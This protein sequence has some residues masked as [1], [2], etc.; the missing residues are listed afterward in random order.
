M[1]NQQNYPT[2]LTQAKKHEYKYW[3]TKPVTSLENPSYISQNIEKN[4][5]NRKVYASNDEI[6][7]PDS[8]RWEKI[9]ISDK[10]MMDKI[11]EFLQKHY[12]IDDTGKFI[13]HYTT[14]FLQWAIGKDNICL[15]IISK[16]T[17]SVCGFVSASF[18]ILT[19]FEA[20]KKFAV[21][22]FLCAHPIYRSKNIAQILIDEIVRQ[23]V[24]TGVHQG[25]FTTDR[26]IPTPTSSMRFYHRPL[27][28]LKLQKYGFTDLELMKPEKNRNPE[29]IQKQFNLV[30]TAKC[31][32]MTLDHINQ[33]FQLYNIYISKYN[34]YTKYT[35]EELTH[36]LLSSN[37]IVNSYVYLDSENNVTDFFSYYKLSSAVVNTEE[38]INAGYLFLYATTSILESK[39]MND[40]MLVMK[41]DNI[42][43][44]NVTD[45]MSVSDIIYSDKL[46]VDVES[47][48][49]S[50]VK[51]YQ[52]GFLKGSGKIHL[53]F[54]NWK[55][56]T[57]TSDKISWTTF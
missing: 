13:L 14:E 2:T 38:K 17:N 4:L 27:N 7:I 48:D 5:E 53:N 10:N 56:P 31:V 41:N 43:V 30:G 29:K 32:P 25:C 16:K 20:T 26:W 9:D 21:V 55:C 12:L 1:E 23:I 33:V 36:Y 19:V 28:Y 24:K 40:I 54:F 42:D 49:E 46:N 8:M 57:V 3:K 6:K 51:S 11:S 44:L 50:F 15:A 52:H 18:K 47:D 45:V 35:L 22:D 39:L 37:Q 34:I